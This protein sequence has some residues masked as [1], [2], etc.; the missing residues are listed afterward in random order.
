MILPLIFL[1]ASIG[2]GIWFYHNGELDLVV[3]S[4]F[5]RVPEGFY[6]QK[7]WYG[8]FVHKIVPVIV[9]LFILGAV[10]ISVKKLMKIKSIHP[11][12]YLKVIY[13]MLVCITGPG[14]V[15]NILFKENFGRA[16]PVQIK[17]FGGYAKFT[18]PFMITNQC[19]NN[20]SF[21]SGHASI[22]FVFCAFA[23]IHQG[24]KRI[25]YHAL[26]ITLG[27]LFG[28]G[29]IMQGA[30]FLSDVIFS[31]VSVYITAY[32]LAKWLLPYEATLDAITTR[33]KEAEIV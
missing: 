4:Y 14:L 15:V 32:L 8:V 27:S 25:F 11:K 5:Y 28:L 29:R 18:P 3:A 30:H 17:E 20:C 9:L 21:V 1:F 33:E 13:V 7:H 24:R 19:N 6:L 16:R 12:Y 31:G 26:A 10:I 2:F 22:G 23:F